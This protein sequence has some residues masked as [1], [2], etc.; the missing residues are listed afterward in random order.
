MVVCM[1]GAW[2][3]LTEVI[4]SGQQSLSSRWHCFLTDSPPRFCHHG[5]DRRRERSGFRIKYRQHAWFDEQSHSDR[6]VD[7]HSSNEHWPQTSND[8]IQASFTAGLTPCD[9]IHTGKWASHHPFSVRFTYWPLQARVQFSR[10]AIA[11]GCF[12]S[13]RY[14]LMV[15]LLFRRVQRKPFGVQG[16]VDKHHFEDAHRKHWNAT[17]PPQFESS[18]R[19]SVAKIDWVKVWLAGP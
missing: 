19:W 3:G 8:R 12:R 16:R 14:F 2:A 4:K 5:R 6:T 7:G 18:R 15:L 10:L 17:S 9:P 13:R 1:G 11:A